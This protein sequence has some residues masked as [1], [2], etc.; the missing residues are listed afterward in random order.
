MADGR[1][2]IDG[3]DLGAAVERVWG[4]DMTEYEWSFSMSPEDVTKLKLAL[5]CTGD[6][7][8]VLEE[9]FSGE[10]VLTWGHFSKL[11]GSRTGL[12]RDSVTGKMKKCPTVGSLMS[13][14]VPHARAWAIEKHG[15]QTYGRGVASTPTPI[16]SAPWPRSRPPHGEA[17]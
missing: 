13:D 9:R 8:A 11:T 17:A 12:G 10:M 5:G 2:T 14:A 4:E 15:T 3:Q 7:L 6:A 16:A 1:L